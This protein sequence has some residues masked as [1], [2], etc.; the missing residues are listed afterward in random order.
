MTTTIRAFFRHGHGD[1]PVRIASDAGVDQLVDDLLAEEFENSLATLYIEGRLNAAGVPDHELAVGINNEE[2]TVGGLRY[3]GG[4]GT[5]YGLGQTSKREE[6]FYLYMGHDRGF[7]LDSEL[8]IDTL[9]KALKEFVAS[10]ERP[11]SVEWR[12]WPE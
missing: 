8:P 7:P 5:F 4:G 2:G 3:M 9:R 1:D 10:G 6:V 12:D 11:S